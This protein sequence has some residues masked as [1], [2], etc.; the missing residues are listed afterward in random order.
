M[1]TE[2]AEYQAGWKAGMEEAA[3]LLKTRENA[4]RAC[5]KDVLEAIKRGESGGC[6]DHLDCWPDAKT[7]WHLPIAKA[8]AAGK[9]EDFDLEKFKAAW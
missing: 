8:E 4:L 3:G 2:S 7:E 5:I 6:I 9:G 1:N